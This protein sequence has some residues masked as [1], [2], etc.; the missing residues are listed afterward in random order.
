MTEF[1]DAKAQRVADAA[2]EKLLRSPAFHG[3]VRQ[4]N[5]HYNRIRHGTPME[6][7]GGMKRDSTCLSSLPRTAQQTDRWLRTDEGE[8]FFKH[9]R[10]E[11]RAQIRGEEK[12]R[13][14]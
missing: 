3:V 5:R 13:K 6:E 9:F 14:P 11:L 2:F 4:I 8:S 1:H 10:D 12:N 7:M